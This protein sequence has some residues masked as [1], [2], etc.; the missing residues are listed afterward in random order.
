MEEEDPS[1][2]KILK[3]GKTFRLLYMQKF[4]PKWLPSGEGKK[5]TFGLEQLN[6]RLRP[7][8]FFLSL[9]LGSSE[10]K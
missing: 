9:V 3:G 2:R 10:R 7:C 4:R 6:A 8:L 1:T 5:I